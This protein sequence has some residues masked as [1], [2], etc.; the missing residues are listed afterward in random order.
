LAMAGVSE[1]APSASEAAAS[2]IAVL[3]NITVFLCSMTVA[4]SGVKGM[5]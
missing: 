5:G 2:A 1:A 4:A 3:F